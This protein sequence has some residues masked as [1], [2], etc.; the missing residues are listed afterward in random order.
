M[1][2][3]TGMVPY[4]G[5]IWWLA[6]IAVLD[7]Q[8][9]YQLCNFIVGLRCAQFLT[10]GRVAI[11]C[12]APT[13]GRSGACGAAATAAAAAARAGRRSGVGAA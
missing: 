4:L 7:R 6:L 3:L 5:Q 10:F 2:Q 9:E 13:H 8:D 1:L 12:V 11:T